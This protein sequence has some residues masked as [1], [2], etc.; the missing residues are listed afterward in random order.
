MDTS[1][2]LMGRVLGGDFRIV[3]PLSQGGMGAVY[4]AEQI[5]TGR[6]RALKTMHAGLLADPRLRARFEQESRVGGRIASEHVVEVMAAGVDGPTGLPWLAMELLEG[7]DLAAYAARRGPLPASE[8]LELFEQIGHAV[9]AAHRVGVVHRDLKPENVFLA[10]M[11]R[12]GAGHTV[13]VLDFGIAKIVADARTSATAA[14]GTPL[15]MAPEQSEAR[16]KV[17]PQ[18][19]VWALG[20]IAFRLLS[21]RCYWSSANVED[22]SSIAVMRE[23]LFDPIVAASARVS[24]LRAAPLPPGFDGWFARCV[25]RDP[26]ARFPDADAALVAL[27]GVLA[28]VPR[29]ATT[30]TGAAPP[31]VPLWNAPTEA[32]GPHVPSVATTGTPVMQPSPS[33]RSEGTELT[34]S[35]PEA[36]RASTARATRGPG[37][38]VAVGL[39]LALAAG[40]VV[41]VVTRQPARESTEEGATSPARRKRPAEEPTAMASAI[42]SVSAPVAVAKLS[43]AAGDAAG[44]GRMGQFVIGALQ[45]GRSWLEAAAVCGARGE[46]LCS[47]VQWATACRKDEGLAKDAVWTSTFA[48]DKRPAIAGGETCASRSSDG[49]TEAHAFRCCTRSIAMKSASSPLV[50]A[51]LERHVLALEKAINDK[52]ASAYVAELAEDIDRVYLLKNPTKEAVRTSVASWYAKYPDQWTLHEWCVAVPDPEGDEAVDCRKVTMW[53]GKALVSDGHYAYRAG[54][55]R[56]VTDPKVIRPREVP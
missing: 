6:Q 12:A 26:N 20:L 31:S 48:A 40:V 14:I 49:G 38:L 54:K 19:D 53:D 18:T 56:V 47:D 44:G 9:G 43:V 15:W 37:L 7:E 11:R 17:G 24:E 46:A 36:P 30:P 32:S 22:A 35:I 5:S 3:R 51:G 10:T 41:F 52:D 16:G 21:G 27:R 29:A 42:P 28:G 4:V 23:V 33:S 1:D 34:P 50:A 2:P 45:P 39:A 55:L 25:D 8:V 13:K